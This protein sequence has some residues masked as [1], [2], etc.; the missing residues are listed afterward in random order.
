MTDT[1]ATPRFTLPLLAVAQAQKE[2][3]HN[4]ALAL[5][6]TFDVTVN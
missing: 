5:A 6:V 4:E 3:T 2:V 1:L